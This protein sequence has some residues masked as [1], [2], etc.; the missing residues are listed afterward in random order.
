MTCAAGHDDTFQIMLLLADEKTV[1]HTVR[2]PNGTWQNAWGNVNG[3]VGVLPAPP[4][5]QFLA[6]G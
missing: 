1:L 4:I 2:N 3:Q 6:G 5:P